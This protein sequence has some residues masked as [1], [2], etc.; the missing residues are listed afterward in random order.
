MAI[1]L[2][3]LGFLFSTTGWAIAQT[4]TPKQD[5]KQ[6]ENAFRYQNY[7]QAK[8]ILRTVLYP[9]PRLQGSKSRVKAREYLAVSHWMLQEKQEARDE[10]TTLLMEFPDHELDPF[11]Y[12]PPLVEL[13]DELRVELQDKG[14]LK[15]R[16]KKKPIVPIKAQVAAAP[17][18]V[19]LLPMGIPQFSQNRT[20]RGWLLLS[21]QGLSLGF[22][23]ISALWIESL[24]GPDGFFSET[25]IDTA[26][27][28]K[29]G[30]WISAGVFTALYAIGV[31]DGFSGQPRSPAIS[32]VASP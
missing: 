18:S 6:A 26:R 3:G 5:F 16:E 19:N 2:I 7:L 28:L 27:G 12:P 10:F 17:W 22:N 30:W 4:P 8:K 11:Y 29:T 23:I 15:T 32:A 9:L 24:R 14:I 21:G 31:I 25:D 1:W 20:T 13:L